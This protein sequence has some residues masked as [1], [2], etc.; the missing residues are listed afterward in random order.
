MHARVNGRLFGT[1]RIYLTTLRRPR[2][3]SNVGEWDATSSLARRVINIL[4]APMYTSL[5]SYGA[6]KLT[7]RR[8]VARLYVVSN[9]E[10]YLNSLIRSAMHVDA[11]RARLRRDNRS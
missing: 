6:T 5:Y 2:Q 8:V 11:M 1:G 10:T 7:S 9:S 3:K 4:G